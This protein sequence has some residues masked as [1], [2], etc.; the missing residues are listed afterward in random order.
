MKTSKLIYDTAQRISGLNLRYEQRFFSA[1]QQNSKNKNFFKN[2]IDNVQDELKR[3]KELQVLFFFF[4]FF[5]ILI[6]NLTLFK[7]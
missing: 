3:N 2:L 5:I 1:Q 7:A 4:S 6:K